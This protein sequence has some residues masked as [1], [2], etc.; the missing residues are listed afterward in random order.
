MITQI[1]FFRLLA[2]IP[3][4][5]GLLGTGFAQAQNSPDP[6]NGYVPPIYGEKLSHYSSHPE[7]RL[8]MVTRQGTIKCQLFDKLAPNHVAQIVRLAKSGFY[9]GTTFHRVIPWFMIQGGEPSTK[10][11]P[12]DLN[13]PNPEPRLK[14]EF[15]EVHHVRGICSMA[16]TNDT[17]SASTGFFIVSYNSLFLDRQ[18]TAWG[19]VTEGIDVV[20]RIVSLKDLSKR[21]PKEVQDQGVN[22]GIESQVLRMYIENK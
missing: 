13:G 17:N 9:D 5:I 14:P 12:F 11:D 21:T 1:R 4:L 3:A 2:L 15:N 6:P 8:V 18:Y 16:R 7:M 19:Q 10:K 20:D 22:P